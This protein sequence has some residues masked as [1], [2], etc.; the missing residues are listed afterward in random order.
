MTIC[1]LKY[2]LSNAYFKIKE[3]H[4]KPPLTT[5]NRANELVWMLFPAIY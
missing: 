3:K 4:I 1:W 2:T 5:Y